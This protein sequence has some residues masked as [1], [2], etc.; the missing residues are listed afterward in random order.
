MFDYLFSLFEERKFNKIIIGV[1][2]DLEERG[3]YQIVAPDFYT[4]YQD[5]AYLEITKKPRIKSSFTYFDS[6]EKTVKNNLNDTVLFG[7]YKKYIIDGISKDMDDFRKMYDENKINGDKIKNLLVLAFEKT[8][9]FKREFSKCIW[10]KKMK[11]ILDELETI[12]K[13]LNAWFSKSTN[14][15]FVNSTTKIKWHGS[16]AQL[17]KLFYYTSRNYLESED[18][19]S[20]QN[21]IDFYFDASRKELQDFVRRNFFNEESDEFDPGTITKNF[22]SKSDRSNVE[23]KK[24]IGKINK[25]T[26]NNTE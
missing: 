15:L 2:S 8:Q 22:N 21:N 10:L 12:E 17:C 5:E 14:I 9:S 3:E 18:G 24:H 7:I 6:D 20:K 13:S 26:K 23:V 16:L 11:F 25:L 1:L 19:K 4:Y